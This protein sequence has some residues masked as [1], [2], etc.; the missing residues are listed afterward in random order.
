MAEPL[1]NSIL[2]ALRLGI[3]E[4]RELPL[5]AAKGGVGLFMANA[6]GKQAAQEAREQNLVRIAR[7]ETRGKTAVELAI[8]TR[9]G[10]AWWLERN[11]P[12]PIVETLLA[13][14]KTSETRCTEL[15]AEAKSI[16]AQVQSLNETAHHLLQ[17]F[18]E[19]KVPDLLPWDRL[20]DDVPNRIVERLKQW[21]DSGKLGD[22]PLPDLHRMLTTA[23]ANLTIGQFHDAL[24]TL[25]DR[26]AVWLHPWTGP[27]YELPEPP[28]SL[29]VGHEV[30]YYASLRA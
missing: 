15:T 12:R 28:L 25:H 14:I 1:T 27:L 7:T 26:R 23:S 9:E 29:L 21:H 4:G 18:P 30:A 10:V 24:R 22:C 5:F 6:A 13:A 11:S 20:Q 19:G 8:P 16:Q 3:A 17:R 2:D